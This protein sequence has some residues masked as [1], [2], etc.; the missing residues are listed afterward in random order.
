MQG[1]QKMREFRA[2]ENDTQQLSIFVK[3]YLKG[4]II[5]TFYR[6]Q[7]ASCTPFIELNAAITFLRVHVMTDRVSMILLL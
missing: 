1:V 3:I 6:L 2:R 5:F 7:R 4:M